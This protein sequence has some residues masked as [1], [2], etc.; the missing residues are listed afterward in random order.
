MLHSLRVIR[1]VIKSQLLLFDDANLIV[2][3]EVITSEANMTL[4]SSF[5][6]GKWPVGIVRKKALVRLV[7]HRSL[8]RDGDWA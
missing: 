7:L 4:I 3:T 8:P 5:G 2:Y 1:D 6:S